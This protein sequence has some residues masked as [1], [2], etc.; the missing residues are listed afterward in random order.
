MQKFFHCIFSLFAFLFFLCIFA[1]DE[2]DPSLSN[3]P[4]LSPSNSDNEESE[5]EEAA[6]VKRPEKYTLMLLDRSLIDWEIHKDKPHLAFASPHVLPKVELFSCKNSKK[7][8]P[9][10]Y[11]Y[12]LLRKIKES[13]AEILIDEL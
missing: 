3:S 13:R 7:S 4:S 8:D 12:R 5:E 9:P 10:H 6:E 2:E 11:S 1:S